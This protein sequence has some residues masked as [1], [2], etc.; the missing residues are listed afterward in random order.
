[1]KATEKLMLAF[2]AIGIIYY[3]YRLAT[4]YSVKKLLNL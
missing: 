2:Y 3:C 1:M 4:L